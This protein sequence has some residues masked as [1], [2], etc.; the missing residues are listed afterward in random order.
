M[1]KIIKKGT[2]DIREC[3]SCGCLFSFDEEDIEVTHRNMEFEKYVLCPQCSFKIKISFENKISKHANCS[4]CAHKLSMY[5]EA[6]CK[7]CGSDFG[8]KNWEPMKLKPMKLKE[9]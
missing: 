6:T 8:F 1:I 9:D 5:P 3:V 2:R 4:N 7:G